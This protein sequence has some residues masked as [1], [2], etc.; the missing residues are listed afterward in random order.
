VD[1]TRQNKVSRLIQKELGEI[2]RKE[3]RN[4]FAGAFI[5][6]TGVRVSPDLST[7]KVYLSFLA[8]KDKDALLKSIKDQAKD[9]RHRL[10]IVVGKQLRITPELIFYIDD[11]L[12]YVEKI[13][14][15]L[16]K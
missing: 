10:T 3:S 12:D 5:T 15:L 9:I 8:V 11:S 13:E 2:F 1:S 4:L 6:V 7:A 14:K 16:K